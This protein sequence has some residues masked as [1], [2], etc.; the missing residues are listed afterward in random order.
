MK[1]IL[2]LTGVQKLSKEQQQQI[3]GTW[4]RATCCGPR[5][6]RVPGTSF[7]DYGYCRSNGS[8]MWA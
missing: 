3:K 4:G 1:S 5:K 6:C 8:C 7:C 2:E